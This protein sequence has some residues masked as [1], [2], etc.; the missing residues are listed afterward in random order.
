MI[1]IVIFARTASSQCSN[2]CS[3]VPILTAQEQKQN[4]EFEHHR[5]PLPQ[6]QEIENLTGEAVEVL[7]GS[8]CKDGEGLIDGESGQHLFICP[9]TFHPC[10][11]SY[12]LSPEAIVRANL[13]H[14][15]APLSLFWQGAEIYSVTS[16][17]LD[18]IVF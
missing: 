1:I 7:H 18:L 12:D 14:F 17:V 11:Y 8:R 10:K 4:S 15:Q 16:Y 3:E 2:Q 9:S 13:G 6:E 5:I